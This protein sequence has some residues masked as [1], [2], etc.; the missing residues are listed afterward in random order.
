MV[1]ALK[2]FRSMRKVRV[3]YPNTYWVVPGCLLAGE[4][5]GDL[6][7]E[8]RS[9]RLSGLIDAGIRIFIDLTLER[10]MEPYCTSLRDLAE[11]RG[12]EVTALR[13]PIPDRDIP[14]VATLRCIL[15]VI[16]RCIANEEPVFVHCF[17]GIGRTGT[18]VGCHL[19]RHGLTTQNDVMD[20]IAELRKSM[21]IAREVSPHTSEQVRMVERWKKGL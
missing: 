10:E 14:S 6:T 12:L 13:V 16:D 7:E 9:T 5:P 21:P 4:H 8:F 19:Q 2:A 17:G 3:P 18:V 15:D 20:K 11:E 1:L